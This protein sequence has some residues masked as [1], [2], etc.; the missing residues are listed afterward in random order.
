MS[1][2]YA[3]RWRRDYCCEFQLSIGD[4]CHPAFRGD[5]KNGC[6]PELKPTVA[7]AMRGIAS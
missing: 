3:A 4:V 2:D 5:D 1:I 7:M 6:Y